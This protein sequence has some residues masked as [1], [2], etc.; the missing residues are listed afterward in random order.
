ML[1]LLVG[2]ISNLLE[3]V[4]PDLDERKRMAHEIATMA[5]KQSHEQMMGQ[6]AL[7][8]AEA[9]HKSLFVAGWRPAVGWVCVIALANN[10]VIAPYAFAAGLHVT[11][12]DMGEMMPVL[13]GMLGFGGLRSFEKHKQVSR[14]K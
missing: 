12:L 11:T 2:P 6:L 13:L 3:K 4:V 10:Y 5:E 7:N 8:K 9:A 1:E 14:E